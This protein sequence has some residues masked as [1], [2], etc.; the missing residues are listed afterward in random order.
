M[1][2]IVGNT[3]MA[4]A[5]LFIGPVPFIHVETQ[6]CLIQGMVGL[7]GFGQSLVMVS[8]FGRAQSAALSFGYADELNTYIMISGTVEYR[9]K[10]RNYEGR[11]FVFEF[12]HTHI[13]YML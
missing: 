8:S 1:V 6:L 4:I 13:S 12:K 2:S 9:I 7:F 11:S 5:L 10:N 3:F